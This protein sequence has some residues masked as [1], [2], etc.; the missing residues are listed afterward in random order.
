M[1]SEIILPPYSGMQAEKEAEQLVQ[2]FCLGR[3]KYINKRAMVDD[4]KRLIIELATSLDYEDKESECNQEQIR[5]FSY[6]IQDIL[7]VLKPMYID[8]SSQCLSRKVYE[9]D[10]EISDEVEKIANKLL[11]SAAAAKWFSDW[12]R[13]V[14]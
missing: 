8:E 10:L 11:S 14:L 7:L 1:I 13:Q 5:E 3:S 12:R 2:N 4:I 6:K 9:H